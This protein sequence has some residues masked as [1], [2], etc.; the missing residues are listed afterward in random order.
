MRTRT[1]DVVLTAFKGLR[2]NGRFRRRLDFALARD[3]LHEAVLRAGAADPAE[4]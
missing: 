3:L 1:G 4:A 2:T